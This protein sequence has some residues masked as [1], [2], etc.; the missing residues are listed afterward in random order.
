MTMNS[1]EMRNENLILKISPEMGASFLEFQGNVRGTWM[2]LMRPTPATASSSSD[3]ASFLMLPYPNRVRDGKFTFEG[4]EYELKFSEKHSI[5]GDVRNRPWQVT[6][7][8]A[9]SCTLEFDSRQVEGFNYPW[10]VKVELRLE[11]ED[12]TLRAVTKIQNVNEEPMPFGYGFHPYFPRQLSAGD[13]PQVQIA[14]DGVYPTERDVPLPT[15]PVMDCTPQDDMRVFG[16]LKN[17]LDHCFGGWS[18][19]A[20]VEWPHTKVRV[21]TEADPAHSHFVV[22]SPENAEFFAYEPQT[23]VNDAYNLAAKGQE[24]T[25]MQTL[26]PGETHESKVWWRVE[27]F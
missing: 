12:T 17:N 23:Q 24:N 1:L 18:G 11:L 8:A 4:R 10:H 26:K 20:V 6:A 15:G 5:H 9:D 19:R 16:P 22:Y 27:V 7:Q 2:H 14:C 3:C 21:I 25:G 13:A